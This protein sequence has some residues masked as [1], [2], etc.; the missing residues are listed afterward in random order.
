MLWSISAGILHNDIM[1][2]S[3]KNSAALN[4]NPLFEHVPIYLGQALPIKEQQG[5]LWHCPYPALHD[6]R[7]VCHS[8]NFF[9]FFFQKWHQSVCIQVHSTRIWDF[10]PVK[11]EVTLMLRLVVVRVFVLFFGALVKENLSVASMCV[12]L[13]FSSSASV[14]LET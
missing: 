8:L 2:S 10:D 7:L 12:P 9:P 14:S 6:S 4:S 13:A 1:L 3:I 5:K 11:M